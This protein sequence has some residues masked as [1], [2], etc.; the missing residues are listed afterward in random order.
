MSYGAIAFCAIEDPYGTS[1]VRWVAWCFGSGSRTLQRYSQDPRFGL[2]IA[3][4]MI[5]APQVVD[6]EIPDPRVGRRPQLR[7]MR[8]RTTSP[9]FQ[10]T[11][12]RAARD[13]PIDGFRIDKASDLIAAIGGRAGSAAFTSTV[14]GGRSIRFRKEVASLGELTELSDELVELSLSVGYRE[15]LPWVDNMRL[16]ED[17]LLIAELQ[18]RLI[19]ELSA[20]PVPASVDAILPD[21]LLEVDDERAIRYIL[22]PRESR[23]MAS[24]HNLTIEAVAQRIRSAPN[25]VEFL[26]T[27]LR[28]LDDAKDAIGR[29]RVIECICAD[30][31]LNGEQ[32]LAYDG[33]FYRVEKTF[34]Q[35]IDGE[36]LQLPVSRVVFPAYSGQ[37]EPQ[38]IELIREEYPEDFVVL[39]RQLIQL[40]GESGVEASDLVSRGGALIHL[41][42][43]GK[44]SMLSHL[45]LQ[46]ANSCELLRRSPQARAQFVE[47]VRERSESSE[48]AEAIAQTH[49]VKLPGRGL[50]VVFG[51]L[52]DWRGRSITSLP[53]FS[54]ISLVQE[55]R[56]VANLG[57]EPSVAL[58][59]GKMHHRPA[60]LRTVNVLSRD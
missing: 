3:L 13:I 34:V 23:S 60:S 25:P 20:Q 39:D 26:S 54:R 5:G 43:K 51:F 28:F 22:Y 40:E 38:Y 36:L 14:L 2:T 19:E 8:Y 17:E 44:S 27:E 57:Y 53:L 31:V 15:A 37:T 4:N 56:K 45:F 7:E 9:Y 16:V 21:D 30:M 59:D 46:V 35:R 33:D 58:I 10:Q 32:F 48:L 49:S 6:S 47:L 29:A 55:S 41:K 24:R 12:H 52:G 18:G 1:R 11:G 50:E 42:R